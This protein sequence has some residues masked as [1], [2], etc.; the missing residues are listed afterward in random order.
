VQIYVPTVILI[1]ARLYLL[2][3]S[4]PRGVI[5]IDDIQDAVPAGYAN[6]EKEIRCK[7]AALY[8]LI[9]HFGWS[10]SIYNHITV[11]FESISM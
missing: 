2:S 8:R 10:Q 7:L 1:H 3:G 9:D 11:K 6:G 5:P 4:I